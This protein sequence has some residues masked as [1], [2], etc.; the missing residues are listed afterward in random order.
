MMK[1]NCSLTF[2]LV[3]MCLFFQVSRAAELPP[4]IQAS[5]PGGSSKVESQ[6]EIITDGQDSVALDFNSLLDLTLNEL[7]KV[8]VVTPS[9]FAESLNQSPSVASVITAD[10]IALFGGRDLVEV[11]SK[12]TGINVLNSL[13]GGRYR[14]TIRGD[15]PSFNVN[16]ILILIDGIPINRES[17]IGGIWTQSIL[18]IPLPIV[19]QIEVVRGPG[20]ALYGSNA[21]SGVVNIITKNSS[22]LKN[23]V[24][25]SY[26]SHNSRAVDLT[27]ATF[28]GNLEF[29][30]ALRFYKSD[31]WP[32][33]TG[34]T[35]GKPLST[36]AA[37]ETPGVLARVRYQ[38]FYATGFWGK[39][40]QV[41][42]RGTAADPIA[43]LTEN[44]RYF[45][46]LGYKHQLENGWEVKSSLS[47]VAGRTDHAVASVDPEQL[48]VIHYETDDSHFE[49]HTLGEVSD[50]L[51]I[52]IGGSYD[53]LTGGVPAAGFPSD[54][55]DWLAGIFAE[56]NYQFNNT[57][58][59]TGFQY[60]YTSEDIGDFVPRLG[61]I[62]DFTENLGI[63]L[64]YG[65]AFRSPYAGEKFLD[66]TVGDLTIKG[67]PKLKPELGTTYDLQ[68]YYQKDNWQSALTLFRNV[69]QDLV[70]RIPITTPMD[71]Y[72]VNKGKLEIEGVEL[73]AKIGLMN[74]WYLT[75]SYTYQRNNDTKG[76]DNF[77]Q[78]PHDIFKLGI[79]YHLENWSVGLFEN[80][81]SKYPN[82]TDISQG[83]A[84]VN[85]SSKA[86]HHL[87]LNTSYE[88]LQF[89]KVKISLYVDNLLD[90]KAYAPEQ[91]GSSINSVPILAERSL[92][93][94]LMFEY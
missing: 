35:I 88:P 5:Q 21:F 30:T 51:Q 31:G 86:Y 7:M 59:T 78:Q 71:I 24:S 36:E 3:F 46:D 73:E 4:I 66:A 33:E 34:S 61:I 64:L 14:F 83:R 41:T 67:N 89:D 48:T 10:E 82:N 38:D 68:L 43:G 29:N 11:L 63:K 40:D 2:T 8:K 15:Q 12:V 42:M 65:Q 17:Y 53:A 1:K 84:Q 44:E 18:A 62:H 94:S 52:L 93:L 28:S 54:W 69:Q 39:A 91:P 58:V 60:N 16:H 47:H 19:K 20:S 72:F 70:V 22:E 9:K 75:G 13:V 57:K 76:L 32:L 23:S 56:A 77:T 85:P 25:L 80:Y 6:G 50:Q 92:M 55:H 87:T 26:G 79:A 45:F 90:E 81:F 27:Y 74:A 37:S 49:L